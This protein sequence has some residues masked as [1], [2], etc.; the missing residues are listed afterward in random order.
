MA[1]AGNAKSVTYD[2]S[3]WANEDKFVISA[4]TCIPL[5]MTTAA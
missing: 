5:A 3:R 2:Q 1:S 4:Q